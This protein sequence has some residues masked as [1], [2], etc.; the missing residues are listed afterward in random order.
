[1]A[2]LA[3]PMSRDPLA[4]NFDASHGSGY[5]V[6]DARSLVKEGT[7]KLLVDGREVYQ[8]RLSSL[9]GSG[10]LPKKFLR[11]REE[12]FSVRIEVAP[13]HHTV[14]AQVFT[15]GKQSGHEDAAEIDVGAHES[16]HLHLV[17]G[18]IMGPSVSIKA[19]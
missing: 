7:V 4:R 9:E 1:M 19:D 10:A 13:G 2:S 5:L 11:R 12:A 17:A 14:S 15:D 18:R 6:I 8:R 3:S 16:A